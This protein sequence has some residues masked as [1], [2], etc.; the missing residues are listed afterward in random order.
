ME[1]RYSFS[2][3][4]DK[5]YFIISKESF[6]ETKELI[7]RLKKKIIKLERQLDKEQNIW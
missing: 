1:E 6:D 7:N 4:D 5:K 2:T 3:P